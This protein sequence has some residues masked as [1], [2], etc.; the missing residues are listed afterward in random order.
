MPGVCACTRPA[1]PWPVFS[2][3]L[4][5]FVLV[6]ICEEGWFFSTSTDLVTW[7]PPIQFFTAPNPEFATGQQTDENVVLV[8]PGNADQV[9]GQTGLVLYA[10]TTAWRNVSHE[11]WARPFTFIKNP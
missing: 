9:I 8:T 5:A 6:F 2:S 1:Q 10:H 4:N 7:T 3:Y 11:L